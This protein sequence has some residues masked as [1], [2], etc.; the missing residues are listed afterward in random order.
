MTSI[1][2][3]KKEAARTKLHE[4]A[5]SMFNGSRRQRNERERYITDRQFEYLLSV[6]RIAY[7]NAK[8]ESWLSLLGYTAVRQFGYCVIFES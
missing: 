6:C 8:D 3:A 1:R 2:E 5:R 7:P 4:L